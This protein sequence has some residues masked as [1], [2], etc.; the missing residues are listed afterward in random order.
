MKY[1]ALTV[2][3]DNTSGDAEGWQQSRLE[4]VVLSTSFSYPIRIAQVVINSTRLNETLGV[5]VVEVRMWST[6]S[7]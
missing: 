3:C 5:M 4:P 2:L 6:P 7:Q 1:A